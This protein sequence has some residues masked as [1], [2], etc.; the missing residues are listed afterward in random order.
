LVM[1]DLDGAVVFASETCALDIVGARL[2]RE[3]E[4]GEIVVVDAEGIRS[5]RPFPPREL[6]RCV[7]EH[8]YFARPDSRIFGGSVDRARRELGQRLARE[9]PAPAAGLAFSR[10]A[11]SHSAPLLFP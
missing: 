3:I 2:V 4:A 9:P 5:L 8:V 1:G 7:F 10:P 6:K 11:S